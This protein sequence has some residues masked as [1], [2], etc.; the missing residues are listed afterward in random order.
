MHTG[1]VEGFRVARRKGGGFQVAHRRVE[2]F[3]LHIGGWRFGRVEGFRV[4][5]RLDRG[6]WS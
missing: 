5:H 2:G 1:R 4:V 6:G 3:R